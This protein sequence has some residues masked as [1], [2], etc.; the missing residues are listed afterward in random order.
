ML[1]PDV[2]EGVVIEV[3]GD[4]F[5]GGEVF[6]D[7]E[8]HRRGRRPVRLDIDDDTGRRI[9]NR[10]VRARGRLRG[11]VLDDTNI[12][13]VSAAAVPAP[14]AA[15][16][17]TRVA[18]LLFNF[19][20]NP[21]QPWAT[22]QVH[23]TLFAPAP[24]TSVDQFVRASSDD[25]TSLSG[26][27][28]GWY[29]IAAP[30]AGCA[31]TTWATQ[32]RA[33]ATNAGVDWASYKHIIYMF[34]N[35]AGCGWAGL[36]YVNAASSWINGR[37]SLGVI[38]HELGHNFGALHA[39]TRRCRESG[40]PVPISSNCTTNEYGDPYSIMGASTRTHHAMHAHR[41]GWQA[42]AT[43]TRSGTYRVAR[44][45]SGG[46]PQALRVPRG[47]TES[48]F[49]LDIRQDHPP[50][51]TFS[52]ADTGARG[53]NI[54][55]DL[56]DIVKYT[57]KIEPRTE[58]LDMTPATA[59]FSD[60]ALLPGNTFT[61]PDTGLTIRVDSVDA[62]GSTV[63]VNMDGTAATRDMTKPS[64]PGNLRAAAVGPD[65]VDLAWNGATD[66]NRVA[67]YRVTRGATLLGSPSG[68]VYRDG[69][70]QPSTTYQYKVEAVDAD[71]NVG[72]AAT[73][74]VTTPSAPDTAAPSTVTGLGFGG[75]DPAGANSYTTIKWNAATDNVGVVGY[76]VTRNGQSRSNAAPTN[77]TELLPAGSTHTWT[78]AAYDA[79]GTVG[80]A[81][82]FTGT[83]PRPDPPPTTAPD[84]TPPS[85]PTSLRATP[86]ST[87]VALAWNA[88]AD[89]VGVRG[90]RIKR[91]A[92]VLGTTPNLSFNISGLAPASQYTFT[93]EAFDAAA[94]Y[95]PT[96]TVTLETAAGNGRS[97][98]VLSAR[99]G[100]RGR[101]FLSWTAVDGVDH[102]QIQ[103]GR[104]VT[105]RRNLAYTDTPG[106]GTWTYRIVGV[107]P[108]GKKSTPSNIVTVAIR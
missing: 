81:A 11:A 102:Y 30:A 90:Y 23:D 5:A 10:R 68:L 50:Y 85:A 52:G 54:R 60:A 93:V 29:P 96:A 47:T 22:Q 9:A 32:A 79:A 20:N 104:R 25:Q 26:D 99:L 36:A 108:N 80:P 84:R 6:H 21:S 17:S 95:S 41:F 16:G 98:S 92:A 55:L 7:F 78:V 27:V 28:F 76:R 53:V 71:G 72:P 31:Y 3:H 40:V 59:T 37:R 51:D 103:R 24:A 39:S 63:T 86:T 57:S 38:A 8:L 44:L 13:A 45:H 73:L 89:N 12:T 100:R 18:V 19:P 74:A 34:P 58:L 70:T 15:A 87:S 88:A 42:A 83:I 49:D 33:A 106:A 14:V 46:S 82:A 107:S 105:E 56:T 94:N 75:F 4:D 48:S 66:N 1:A 97:A 35:V 43:V 77:F 69:A 65:L 2:L 64:A 101:V 67:G 61:D 62:G 91:G